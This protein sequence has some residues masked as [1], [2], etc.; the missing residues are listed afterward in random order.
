VILIYLTN[1]AYQRLFGDCENQPQQRL[2]GHRQ[3][4]AFSFSAVPLPPGR[5]LAVTAMRTVVPLATAPVAV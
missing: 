5:S 2:R 3:K 4:R 1:P